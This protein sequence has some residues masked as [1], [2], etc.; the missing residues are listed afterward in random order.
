MIEMA[1]FRYP[2][3]ANDEYVQENSLCT[4]LKF[5]LSLQK[6]QSNLDYLS[7]FDIAVVYFKTYDTAVY[8]PRSRSTKCSVLSVWIL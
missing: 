4:K 8:L 1:I 6:A 7:K 2:D 5:V 3:I